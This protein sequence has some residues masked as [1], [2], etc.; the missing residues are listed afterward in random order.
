MSQTNSS[1]LRSFKSPSFRY[2]FT[3]EGRDQSYALTTTNF[4]SPIIQLYAGKHIRITLIA[5][6]NYGALHQHHKSGF[7]YNSF[8]MSSASK[9]RKIAEV[10][11]TKYYAVKA[12]HTPGVYTD[13]AECQKNTTGF[14]GASCK[15]SLTSATL[16]NSLANP[17]IQSRPSQQ[18]RKQKTSSPAKPSLRPR[19]PQEISSTP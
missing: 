19:N 9:K 16:K 1:R 10:A 5:L 12:G 17:L 13:Y 18:S 2:R 15:L 4:L 7:K 6:Y 14:R 11:P 8:T 3:R